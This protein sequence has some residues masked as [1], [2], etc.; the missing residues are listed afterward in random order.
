D[1]DIDFGNV[2]AVGKLRSDFLSDVEHGR[3]VALALTDDN[4]S[5]H[6]NGLHA[7]AHGFGG[8]LVRKLARPLAHGAR[9]GNRSDFNDS[10]EFRRKVAFNVLAKAPYLAFFARRTRMSRHNALQ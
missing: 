4:R 7:L 9:R 8:D 2:A 3:L 6:R 1:G 5:P 10:Q